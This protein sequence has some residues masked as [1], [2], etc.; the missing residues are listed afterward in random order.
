MKSVEDRFEEAV[1][2]FNEGDFFKAHEVWEEQW[3]TAEGR[4]RVFYQGLIQAA[5]AL[6]HARRGNHTG[7]TSL[8]LKCR[9]KL[10]LFPA[11]WE[12]IEVEQLRVDLSRYFSTSPSLRRRFLETSQ[13]MPQ[14]VSG[15]E[16]PPV[17]RKSSPRR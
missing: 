8:Y 4:D 2:L 10:D 6:L 12:G 16:R 14:R 15:A 7:A 9:A 11:E 17:I 3:K 1:R 13:V 5:A